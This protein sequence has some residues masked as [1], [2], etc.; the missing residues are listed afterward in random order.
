MFVGTE[1][2][3]HSKVR[4][5][6]SEDHFATLLPL[7]MR[8]TQWGDRLDE[9]HAQIRIGMWAKEWRIGCEKTPAQPMNRSELVQSAM[10]ILLVNHF[11][12]GTS[13]R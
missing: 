6:L 10:P 3:M 8:N 1:K 5:A 7:I 4:A 12:G 13:L 2:P 9:A 11:V